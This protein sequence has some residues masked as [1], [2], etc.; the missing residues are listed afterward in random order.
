MNYFTPIFN[1]GHELQTFGEAY[2]LNAGVEMHVG[3]KTT[4]IV[5]TAQQWYVIKHSLYQL[6]A[7]WM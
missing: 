7:S 1:V 4:Y 5:Y 2:F 6:N 3:S